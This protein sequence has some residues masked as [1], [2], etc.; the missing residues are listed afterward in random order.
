MAIKRNRERME[1]DIPSASLPDIVFQLLIFF[2]VTTTID[3]DKGL[4]LI[5]P[6]PGQDVIEIREKNIANVLINDA[7]Q[8]LID[9][10]IVTAEEVDNIVRDKLL[11]NPKL[12]ISLKTSRKTKYEIYIKVLDQLKRAGATRISIAEPEE[13]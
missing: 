11:D 8:I 13:A 3:V 5:L 1:P 6:P 12:I 9:Q 4:D 2:L 10:E 7:G